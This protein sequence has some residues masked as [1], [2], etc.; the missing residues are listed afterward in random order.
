MKNTKPKKNISAGTK[1]NA[2]NPAKA[3]K[4][5][6]RAAG[7][8]EKIKFLSLMSCT[9]RSPTSSE[10]ATKFSFSLL[11]VTA[12]VSLRSEGSGAAM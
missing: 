12:I 6:Q 7:R 4:R 8:I 10:S 3:S 9:D 5:W 2:T 1:K 11:T